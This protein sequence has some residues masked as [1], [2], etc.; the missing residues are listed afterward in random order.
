MNESLEDF[1]KERPK[2]RHG[3]VTVWLL[4]GIFGS[5]VLIFFYVVSPQTVHFNQSVPKSELIISGVIVML[6][7]VL[8]IMLL[9]WKKFGFF[10]QVILSIISFIINLSDGAD[11]F[12]NL[13]FSFIGTLFLYWVLQFKSDNGLSTWE[14]LE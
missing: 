4:L 10:A 3:C 6:G 9:Q 5:I 1:Q 8:N 12:M 14:Q 11:F 13:I 2:N 7:A